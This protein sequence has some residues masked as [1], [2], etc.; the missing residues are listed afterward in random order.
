MIHA[1]KLGKSSRLTRVYALLKG[2]KK[3]STRQIIKLADVCAVNSIIS[4]LRANGIKIECTPVSKG[5][6]EYQLL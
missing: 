2:G 6:Y 4:E 3:Y 5:K 1:A